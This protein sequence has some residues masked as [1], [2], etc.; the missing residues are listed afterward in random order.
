LD[1]GDLKL[2]WVLP[3]LGFNPQ[4]WTPTLDHQAYIP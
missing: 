3:R 1:P 4:T 2:K